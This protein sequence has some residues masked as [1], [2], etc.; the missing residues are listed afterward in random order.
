MHDAVAEYRRHR[1]APD[2]WALGR[3]VV[4]LARWT[5]FEEAALAVSRGERWPVSVLASP[6]DAGAVAALL[7]RGTGTGLA[8]EAVEWR[9]SSPAEVLKAAGLV[10][11]VSEVFVEAG[12]SG[13][14][15]EPFAR[16]V[17]SAGASAKM[18]TG[19][20]SADAFPE[21]AWV[22]AFLRACWRA[23]VRFK[24]TAGLHHA[25]RGRYA[26]TYEPGSDTGLMYGFLNVAVAAALVWRGLDDATVL[27]ALD[28]RSADAFAFSEQGLDWRGVHLS[29]ADLNAVRTNFLAGLG[30]CSFREPLTELGLLPEP[31]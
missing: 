2:Q 14:E 7:A 10:A 26:L 29:T 22:L 6:P 25:V 24:A 1:D 11:L 31:V 13:A 16:A 21:P 17:R 23:G 20:L 30:S 9:A 28:E 27:A 5:E 15:L 18:R 19:G 12:A 8:I 4:P 3:F